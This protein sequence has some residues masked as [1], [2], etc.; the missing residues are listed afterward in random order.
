MKNDR[1][2]FLLYGE[3]T[4]KTRP[5]GCRDLK[6]KSIPKSALKYGEALDR[7]KSKEENCTE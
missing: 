7:W 2:K 4:E 1:F 3:L 5:V 6:Y